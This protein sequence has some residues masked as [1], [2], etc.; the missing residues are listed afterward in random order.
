MKLGKYI[1]YLLFILPALIIGCSDESTP[2][3]DQV[4]KLRGNIVNSVTL[5]G[6]AK[7]IIGI[8]NPSVPD[9][10]VF[11]GDTLNRKVSNA[12]FMTVIT[13]STGF[14][15][16]DWFLGGRRTD[17]YRDIFAYKE[18]YSLWRYSKDSSAIV[19][20]VNELTDE[21]NI[22]LVPK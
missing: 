1:C 6:E 4:Y 14:Y 19:N 10:L 2:T 13:D 11:A 18:G 22:K 17:L 15:E 3:H 16:W 20:Q 5:K 21:L 8:K 7:A 9:S 12:F